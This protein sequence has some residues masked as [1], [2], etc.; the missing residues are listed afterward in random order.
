MHKYTMAEDLNNDDNNNNNNNNNN[1]W[2]YVGKACFR[3]FLHF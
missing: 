2:I 3:T 1:N